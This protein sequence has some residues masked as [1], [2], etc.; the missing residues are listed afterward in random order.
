MMIIPKRGATMRVFIGCGLCLFLLAACSQEHSDVTAF[1]GADI[2]DGTGSEMVSNG[3]IL[4]EGGRIREAGLESEVVIPSGSQIEDLSGRTIVPGLIN[5]HGHVGGVLGLES[6]HYNRDNL[7]RQL[8]LYADYGITTVNSLGGD[9]SEGK[10]LRDEQAVSDL[11]RARLYIAGEVITGT[12]REEVL[13]V[14]SE[15]A[16]LGVDWMKIRVDDNL[17]STLKMSE[18]LY[19][20]I[21]DTSHELGFRLASHLFYLE[22]AKGLL[23]AGTDF[24]AH[25]V[26]D[27]VVDEEFLSLLRQSGICYSPTL[28]R[29]VSTFVYENRPDFFDDPFF[30]EHPDPEVTALRSYVLEEL[31]E[32][33]RQQAVRENVSAQG[34][35]RALPVAME[36]LNKISDA[37]LPIGFGTD[38]G[39]AGRFQGFFEHMELV[40][41]E[42]SG[43]SSEQ[44]LRSA[45]GQAAKCL[46]LE[47]EVGTLQADRWADFIV[48]TENPLEDVRNM[49]TIESVWIA[50]N[51]I[52]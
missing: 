38:T 33:S 36:N 25:S 35:K 8:R 2:W 40:L 5:T 31:S 11:N 41:M 27:V 21:I 30:L 29:E 24:I 12:T 51:R 46:G 15:N 42:R 49:R 50:G 44:I 10:L 14:L 6:G 34:Y 39:P 47:E 18:E 45:T 23:R 13:E 26:R 22:D 16:E 48:L 1:V 37:G 20:V 43:M 4:V 32:P 28:T 7:I 52:G 9:G 17:G 19:S 3:V